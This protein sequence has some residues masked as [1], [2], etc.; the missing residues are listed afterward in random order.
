MVA[1]ILRP[2]P[3]AAIPACVC[4]PLVDRLAKGL[5]CDRT[6]HPVAVTFA[7]LVFGELFGSFSVLL[8]SP[9][10][11]A[12]LV[13]LRRLRPQLLSSQLQKS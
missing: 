12:L 4:L 13:G 2:L 9:A 6:V 3:F 10:S 11:A 5:P 7:L 8:A 1:P